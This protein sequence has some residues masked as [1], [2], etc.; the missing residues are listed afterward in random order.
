MSLKNYESVII[1][2]PVLSE[3]QMQDTVKG[4]RE[5]ITEQGG[6]VIHETNWGLAKFAYPIN[7][8]VTG[9]YHIFEFQAEPEFIATLELSYRRDERVMRFL[10][11][12]LDKFAVIY[13]ER[14]RKGEIGKSKST[15]PVKAKKKGDIELIETEDLED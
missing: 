15:E 11:T 1:L 5:L 6:K 8:K 13:N 9:F 12:A 14:K 4:Y 3:Q 7:K 10:T 2:T